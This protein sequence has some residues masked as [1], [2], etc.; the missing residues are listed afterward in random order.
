M[1]YLYFLVIEIQFL[2]KNMKFNLFF[3]KFGIVT[4]SLVQ[5][6]EKLSIYSVNCFKANNPCGILI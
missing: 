5:I 3:K 1:K 6:N 4:E 2:I